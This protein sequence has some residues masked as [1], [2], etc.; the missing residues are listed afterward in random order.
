V[1][2][3]VIGE[4]GI[5]FQLKG[6][7]SKLYFH[8]NRNFAAYNGVSWIFSKKRSANISDLLIEGV[9]FIF[10]IRSHPHSRKAWLSFLTILPAREGSLGSFFC[11]WGDRQPLSGEFSNK[12]MSDFSEM[13]ALGEGLEEEFSCSLNQSLVNIEL[14]G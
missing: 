3:R 1:K 7:G 12:R 8:L 6:C 5:A 14:P 4:S 13:A 10:P 9:H 2:L 11:S